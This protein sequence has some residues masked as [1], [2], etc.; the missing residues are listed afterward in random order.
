MLKRKEEMKRVESR[1]RA[2]LKD[3]RD[4]YE[5]GYMNRKSFDKWYDK[6]LGAMA[7]KDR[8]YFQFRL[9]LYIPTNEPHTYSLG[10]PQDQRACQIDRP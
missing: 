3:L 6:W 1:G 10:T 9:K 7:E 4:A 8:M 2:V 5:H